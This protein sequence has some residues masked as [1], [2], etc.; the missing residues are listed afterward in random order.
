MDKVRA[1]IKT[2]LS[3]IKKH[4]KDP[5]FLGIAAAAAVLL[6]VVI[7]LA[8]GRKKEAAETNWTRVTVVEPEPVPEEEAAEEESIT[9][10][11]TGDNLMHRTLYENAWNGETYDFTKYYVH[12][13]EQVQA[14]DIATINQESPLASDLYD[15][16]T[17]P[18]FNSP[19]QVGAA[20]I[21]TGFDI[22]NLAN[23]HTFDMGSAGAAITKKYFDNREV[24]TVGVYDDYSDMLNIR[25]LEV[26]GIRVAFLS[27][28][29]MLNHE[30]DGYGA[31]IVW[32]QDKKM[33]EEQIA[34]A[35]K[36]SDIIVAHVH[37]GE[38]LTTEL[39][40]RQKEYAQY[41]VDA[42]IDIIFG[43][44]PH[45]LQELTTLTRSSDGRQCPVAYS[46]GNFVTGMDR[47][48]EV[49]TG[50]LTV[51]VSKDPETGE[52][53]PDAM[54]FTPLVL[55]FTSKAKKDLA[56][57]PLTEYTEEMAAANYV[58]ELRGPFDLAY[59]QN[60]IDKTIP[61]RYQGHMAPL[62]WHK[63]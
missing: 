53:R 25:V 56:I 21:D 62:Y 57:Y 5:V 16:S 51:R 38:E 11:C 28:I 55:Q 37:W 24:P 44:H 32:M 29:E 13:K 2:F 34:E 27:F 33:V 39:T 41:L 17:Y 48:E 18:K 45:W 58:N 20:I 4:K 42:G 54:E 46:L 19:K 43:N 47:R 60:I 6:I 40:D 12:V 8:G 35:K 30:A 22:V 49:V 63:A 50:F 7:A 14:A 61:K 26:K 10:L 23:N 31:E 9:I 59:I 1:V 36:V 52:V 3:Y 15:L